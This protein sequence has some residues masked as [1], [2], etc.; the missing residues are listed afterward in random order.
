MVKAEIIPDNLALEPADK[1]TRVCA[2]IGQPP[3]P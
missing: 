3:I 2:I 1:F